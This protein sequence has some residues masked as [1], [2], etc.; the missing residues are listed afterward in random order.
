ML[1]LE[2]Q[3]DAQ[4]WESANKIRHSL[5]NQCDL[6]WAA[7]GIFW[8]RIEYPLSVFKIKMIIWMSLEPKQKTFKDEY[9]IKERVK[10]NFISGATCLY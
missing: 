9:K 7:L 2:Q 5:C 8:M 4:N 10:N 3:K 6:H 1:S